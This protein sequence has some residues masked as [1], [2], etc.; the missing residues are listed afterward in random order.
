MTLLGAE[1]LHA[2]PTLVCEFCGGRES[3]PRDAV[4]QHR[5]LRLRLLQVRRA[6]D[7]AEAP[8]AT[9]QAVRQGW[10][11]ALVALVPLAGWQWWQLFAATAAPPQVVGF[12]VLSGAAMVGVMCGY[13]GMHRAFARWVK[14]LL[15]AR[16]PV[17]H[18][19][20][21]R[22]RSCGGTLPAVRAPSV[23]C[24]YCG[25]ANLLDP[26]L[27]RDASALLDAERAEHERR[28]RGDAAD[29]SAPYAAP[30]RAFV[31]WGLIGAAIAATAGT[32]VVCFGS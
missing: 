6:R 11:I 31:R 14:P 28:V 4:E 17:K 5:H 22:C 12:A 8:I 27:A 3:L 19:L 1:A 24:T 15:R 16:P 18:G 32:I 30:S 7:L 23:T 13:I 9:F 26:A 20:A 2:D 29:H 21:A 10:A 25:A